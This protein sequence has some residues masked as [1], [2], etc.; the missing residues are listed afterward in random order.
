MAQ[1]LGRGFWIDTVVS[2][3]ELLNLVYDAMPCD[4]VTML[5]T[6]VGAIP[7]SSIPVILREYR[8]APKM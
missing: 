3:A 8:T 1:G 7:P 4:F 5:I 2:N 6:E